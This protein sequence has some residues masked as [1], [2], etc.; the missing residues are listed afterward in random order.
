MKGSF[1]EGNIQQCYGILPE[2][3]DVVKTFTVSYIGGQAFSVLS[4]RKSKFCSG[5]LM[6]TYKLHYAFLLPNLRADTHFEIGQTPKLRNST[7]SIG[8]KSLMT[9]NDPVQKLKIFL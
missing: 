1:I 7:K 9:V 2:S 3:F 6:N 5:L 8:R 4:C